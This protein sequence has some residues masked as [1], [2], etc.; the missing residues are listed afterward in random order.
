MGFPIPVRCHLH[1]ESG[2]WGAN[3][4]DR[5]E[6]DYLVQCWKIKAFTSSSSMRSMLRACAV[7]PIHAVQMASPALQGMGNGFIV[8]NDDLLRY[9]K[10]E[11]RKRRTGRI[12][13]HQA[14][15]FHVPTRTTSSGCFMLHRTVHA[16]WNLYGNPYKNRAEKEETVTW[17]GKS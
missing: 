4:N 8:I 17:W 5:Q 15:L 11:G 10:R 9:G 13:V 7:L 3:G 2:P 16:L 14:R 6:S 1:I 12:Q